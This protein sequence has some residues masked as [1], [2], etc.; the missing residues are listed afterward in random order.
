MTGY[1]RIIVAARSHS[2][3]VSWMRLR[4]TFVGKLWVHPRTYP[5]RLPVA[6]PTTPHNTDSHNVLRLMVSGKAS[7]PISISQNDLL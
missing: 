5:H 2:R 7:V 6:T 3:S 4:A 1:E